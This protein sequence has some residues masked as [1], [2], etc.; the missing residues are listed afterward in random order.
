M[1]GHLYTYFPSRRLVAFRST[2]VTSAL[3]S[4][5][6][7]GT[8]VVFLPGVT[9]GFLALSYYQDFWKLLSSSTSEDK[10]RRE[11][12][13]YQVQLSSF[14]P[15]GYGMSSIQKDA[16]ELL[17]FL[18]SLFLSSF[19][20]ITKVILVGHS[21]GCQIIITLLKLIQHLLSPSSLS[22]LFEP[23]ASDVLSILNSPSPS[24]PS[25]SLYSILMTLGKL[26]DGIVLQ[27]PVSDRDFL[28]QMLDPSSNLI[29]SKYLNSIYPST[30]SSVSSASTAVT[31]IPF[32]LNPYGP[33]PMTQVRFLSLFSKGS[34]E[35]LFSS[36]LCDSELRTQL[37]LHPF[38][39]TLL[40]SF[41]GSSI[42][43]S[44]ALRVLLVFSSK[45]EYV[46]QKTLQFLEDSFA[47]RLRNAIISPVSEEKQEEKEKEKES[48]L[49]IAKTLF[50]PNSNHAIDN[51]END[52][53]LFL[54][55]L[56]NFVLN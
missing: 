6:A 50:L 21:T 1:D 2:P 20:P 9:D 15:F 12:V 51:D 30:S 35:D 36:D 44:S 19:S 33:H 55:S 43:V 24:F 37:S 45:D 7:S 42:S 28:M 3:S 22:S 53:E 10:E 4:S 14:G 17:V 52:R 27:G 16:E 46:T 34:L 25:P 40:S 49:V 41:P 54:S 29:Y 31:L 23:V 8:V 5:V 38:K 26:I 48:S 13:C 47:A 39:Q 32:E 18:H 56:L 11:V